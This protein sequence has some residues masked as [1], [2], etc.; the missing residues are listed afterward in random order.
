MDRRAQAPLHSQLLN[1]ILD[2]IKKQ[3]LKPGDALPSESQLCR[4]F[5]VSRTVV[6]QTLAQLD[7]NGVVHRVQGKGTFVS[8]QKAS[9]HL[10]HTMLGLY[11]DAHLRGDSVKSLI[12]EHLV[13]PAAGEVASQLEVAPG[14]PIVKLTRMRYVNGEPW[15]LSTAWLPEEIGKHSFEADLT[16][17]SLYKLLERNGISGVTGWRSVEAVLADRAVAKHLG[18]KLG[19]PLLKLKSLRRDQSG[20]AIEYFEAYHRGD[21]SRFEFELTLEHAKGRVLSSATARA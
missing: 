19:S 21:K 12:L 11:E 8:Q 5:G 20:Q 16:T 14:T 17:E 2:M 3:G 10:G 7:N 4:E 9:E 6:R 18:A 1:A 13:E 15:A